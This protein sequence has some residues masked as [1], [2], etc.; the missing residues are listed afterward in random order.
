MNHRKILLHT[1]IVGL[2]ATGS[3][4]WLGLGNSKI[5]DYGLIINVLMLVSAVLGGYLRSRKIRSFD[6]YEA[7]I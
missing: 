3:L 4:W 2:L 5:S 6:D 1:L 7:V